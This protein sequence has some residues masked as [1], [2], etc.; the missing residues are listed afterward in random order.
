MVAQGDVRI[1]VS[2]GSGV[3][4]VVH[5]NRKKEHPD[6][7]ASCS[8]SGSTTPICGPFLPQEIVASLVWRALVRVGFYSGQAKRLLWRSVRLRLSF[9][10]FLPPEAVNMAIQAFS[11]GAEG[12]DGMPAADAPSHAGALHALCDEHFAYGFDNAGT[13]G[14]D[15]LLNSR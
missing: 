5:D 12:E 10:A 6:A 8:G 15:A 7:T 1:H 9:A 13:D 11:K 14:G 2:G 3:L 4:P